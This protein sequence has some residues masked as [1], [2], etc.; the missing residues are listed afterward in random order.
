MESRKQYEVFIPE[1]G[2]RPKLQTGSIAANN[3]SV[4]FG[5]ITMQPSTHSILRSASPLDF[6]L[7]QL[8]GPVNVETSETAYGAEPLIGED[9]Q[10]RV[11]VRHFH[12][13]RRGG[14]Y[15][16]ERRQA[17]STAKRQEQVGGRS[18]IF[19]DDRKAVGWL[20]DSDFCCTS[21][22][23]QLMLVVY[24]PGK[25]LHHF[26]GDGR[27]IFRWGFVDGGKRVAFYQDFLHGT[28]GPHYEL[29]DVRVSG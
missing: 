24:T 18:P 21:Y 29:H 22:P 25:P 1:P 10:Q 16:S 7:G 20:V 3:E 17:R 23:I 12:W 6:P 26:M 2:L 8:H 5:R 14:E 27:A 15:S 13:C 19:S 4:G 9:R 28:A 11:P